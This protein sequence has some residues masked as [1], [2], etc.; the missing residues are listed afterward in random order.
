MNMEKDEA[1]KEV[2]KAA[3]ST[4]VELVP[5]GYSYN[6]VVDGDLVNVERL[7]D[8]LIL[9]KLE[10]IGKQLEELNGKQK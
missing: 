1:K 7:E 10:K 5:T 2:P 8:A 6:V 4:S 3:K 9:V